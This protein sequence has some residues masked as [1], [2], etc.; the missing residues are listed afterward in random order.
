MTQ[1]PPELM[2]PEQRKARAEEIPNE[3]SREW[4]RFAITE[5]VVLWLPFAVYLAVYVMTDAVSDSTHV[6]VVVLGISISTALVL[7][8]LF[9]RIRPLQR[10]R[11]SLERLD[12][13]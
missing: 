9:K 3:I 10:E 8:W 7:Y 12:G 6:P 5:A 11:E 1:L 13:A 4:M 2:S